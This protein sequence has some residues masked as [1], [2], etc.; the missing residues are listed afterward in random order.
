MFWGVDLISWCAKKQEAIS[1]SSTEAEYRS[2]AHACA[3][4]IWVSYLLNE[5]QF[6]SSRPIPLL[7][8]HLNTTYMAFDSVFH[9][10]IKYIEL[11]YHYILHF[12]WCSLSSVYFVNLVSPR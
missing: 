7:Y 11:D 5:L 2:I 6:P 12:F 3:D 1:R 4:T 10:R 9:G 8:D